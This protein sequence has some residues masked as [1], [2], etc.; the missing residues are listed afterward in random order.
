MTITKVCSQ[1]DFYHDLL[2]RFVTCARGIEGTVME[3][4]DTGAKGS[5]QKVRGGHGRNT[6]ISYFR[7]ISPCYAG[8]YFARSPTPIMSS[9]KRTQAVDLSHHVSDYAR[10]YAPSPL[11]DL[12][13][14]YGEAEIALAGGGLSLHLSTNI[15]LTYHLQVC[16]APTTF[17]SLLFLPTYSPPTRSRAQFPEPPLPLP[18]HPSA[19]YGV[20]LV[21]M[22]VAGMTR[23]YG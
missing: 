4:T 11:K 17:H 3:G 23:R 18:S 10:R 9:E 14:Y 6:V 8:A 19:G 22:L 21:E 16:R 12:Q 1:Y 2:L 13:R 5:G 7:I 15:A 20:S